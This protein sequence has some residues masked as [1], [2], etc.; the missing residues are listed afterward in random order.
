MLFIIHNLYLLAPGS[1]FRTNHRTN[2]LK[3]QEV[4]DTAPKPDEGRVESWGE[5]VMRLF[6]ILTESDQQTIN[7]AME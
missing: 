4:Q 7:N 1:W 2:Y 5:R 6:P 3:L